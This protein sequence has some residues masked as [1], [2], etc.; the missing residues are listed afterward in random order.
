MYNNSEVIF[1]NLTLLTVTVLSV[2]GTE[3]TLNQALRN[4]K[5]QICHTDGNMVA[6]LP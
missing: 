5:C 2:F 4:F 3:K 6:A 1:L